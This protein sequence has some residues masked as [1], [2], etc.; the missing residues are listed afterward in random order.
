M[1]FAYPLT[2]LVTGLALL[3]YVWTGLVVGKARKVHGVDYPATHGPDGFNRVWR[4]HMNTLE[5]LAL[6]LPSLWLFAIIVSDRW[7]AFL[8]LIWCLGRIWYVN[9]YAKA[10][11][12][13]STGFLIGLLATAI[14]LFGALGVVVAQLLR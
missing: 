1:D 8:G 14:C 11:E 13:R 4:A 12:K 10:P 6:F 2:A 3:V 9:G 5:Q 7:A